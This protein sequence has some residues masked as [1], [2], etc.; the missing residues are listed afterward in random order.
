M[1]FP[2][3]SVRRVVVELLMPR[4]LI[5]K[6]HDQDLHH[7]VQRIQAIKS[8]EFPAPLLSSPVSFF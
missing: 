2:S 4:E 3:F 8:R 1:S 5:P 7:L 6:A